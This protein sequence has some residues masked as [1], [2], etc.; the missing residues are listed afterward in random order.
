MLNILYVIYIILY[1]Y[2]MLFYYVIYAICYVIS[3]VRE[4]DLGREREKWN[5]LKWNNIKLNDERETFSRWFHV[6]RGGEPLE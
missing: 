3:L 2:Y 1:R 4:R 5:D 6:V